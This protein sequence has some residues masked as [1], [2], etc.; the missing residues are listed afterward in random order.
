MDWGLSD[1]VS[2]CWVDERPVF[3]DLGADRYY[4]LSGA[5]ERAFRMLANGDPPPRPELD[6][7]ERSRLVRRGALAPI[8]PAQ[9]PPPKASL[10]DAAGGRV[11]TGP[12]AV[13]EVAFRL[14][15]ARRRVTRSPLYNLIGALRARKAALAR[16][17]AP[18]AALRPR[19]AAAFNAARRMAPQAL[20]CLPDAL[21]LLEYMGARGL[22]ADLVFGVRLDPFTAHCWVQDKGEVLNDGLDAV[23][24]YSPI[25]VV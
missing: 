11:R 8:V 15:R 1:Q 13:A 6:A 18:D 20:A 9:A 2:F 12:L 24:T 5:A 4:C 7:L 23:L 21:A 17:A 10:V 3:L 19:L 25:L 22:A 16:R 14:T